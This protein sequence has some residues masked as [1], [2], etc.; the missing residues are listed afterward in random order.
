MSAPRVEIRLDKVEANARSLVERLARR[1]IRV[2]GVTKAALGA[3]EVGAAFE[4]GGVAGL[5]DSRVQN[6]KRLR[7]GGSA[8]ARTLIRSPM[9]SEAQLVVRDADSSLNTEPL[10]LDALAAAA[11]RLGTS[12]GVV[13]MV[14]LGDLREGIDPRTVVSLACLVEQTVG[15]HLLGLG[16]NLA[17]QSGIAPD[18]SKMDQLSALVDDVESTLQRRLSVVSGGNSANLSWAL[19][20]AD[21]GRVD[22][23]RLGE[24]ILLGTE[25]LH[26][27]PVE[28]LHTDACVLVA[29]VIEVQ[30]KASQPWG[31]VAQAA[32]GTPPIRDDVGLRRQALIALGHQDVDPLGLVPPAGS[33]ILG[34]SSDHLVVDVSELDVV[35][36]DELAF[37]PNYSAL[38]RAMTSPFVT[39]TYVGSGAPPSL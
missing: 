10:V 25:P 5:G 34:A 37:A 21:V 9:I 1:G 26:R 3:P 36:G 17:C 2:V 7:D 19:S 6:L 14:E 27:T 13:L 24:S 31:T 28:G 35:V 33:V 32:F 18:D 4:R 20:A 16:T 38:V 30:T 11:G 22:E 12:H 29:E 15:L 39:T 23:L 8:L